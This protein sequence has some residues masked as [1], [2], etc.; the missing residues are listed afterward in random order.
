[1][2]E[3]LSQNWRVELDYG[4]G[5][6]IPESEALLLVCSAPA[7]QQLLSA[8]GLCKGGAGASVQPGSVAVLHTSGT[9][10]EEGGSW[11]LQA[12]RLVLHSSELGG[13]GDSLRAALRDCTADALH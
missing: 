5:G 6:N 8:A 1:M 13:L 3:L 10:G 2:A 12:K 9:S 11:E 7:V 4:L